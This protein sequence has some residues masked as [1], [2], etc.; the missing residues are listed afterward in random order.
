MVYSLNKWVSI[1]GSALNWFSFYISDRKCQV[2]IDNFMSSS[3]PILCGV[4]Q[5]SILGPILFS[6]YMLPLGNLIS[7]FNCISRHCYVD[8][9]QLYFSFKHNNMAN[10]STLHDCMTD[11]YQGLDVSQLPSIKSRQNPSSLLW[12]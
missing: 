5:G 12:S 3:A 8:D 6:L 2:L 9:L 10:I 1:L 7:Q 4:L 11:C